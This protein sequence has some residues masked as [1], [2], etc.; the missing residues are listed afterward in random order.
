MQFTHSLCLVSWLLI[1]INTCRCSTN[2]HICPLEKLTFR[3]KKEVSAVLK[4][5]RMCPQFRGDYA[6][7]CVSIH[8][9]ACIL[10]DGP[11]TVNEAV[12]HTDEWLKWSVCMSPTCHLVLGS[13]VCRNWSRLPPQTYWNTGHKLICIEV[14][15]RGGLTLCCVYVSE[16][17]HPSKF[18]CLCVHVCVSMCPVPVASRWLVG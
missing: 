15:I 11:C 18:V 4:A 14:Y 1:T 6:R 16:N 10:C 12:W 8:V 7:A 5:S 9:L 2:M 13:S 17:M 3:W